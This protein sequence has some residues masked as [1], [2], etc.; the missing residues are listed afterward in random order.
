MTLLTKQNKYLIQLE[1]QTIPECFV[2]DHKLSPEDISSRE[3]TIISTQADS[4]HLIKGKSEPL[5]DLQSFINFRFLM[6]PN[7]NI[8]NNTQRQQT[9]GDL[10]YVLSTGGNLV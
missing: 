10:F 3:R 8:F 5:L 1:E 9:E 6:P 2:L 4:V 7:M